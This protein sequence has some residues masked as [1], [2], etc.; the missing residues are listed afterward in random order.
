MA[1]AEKKARE[2]RLKKQ[3]ESLLERAEEHRIKAATEKGNKDTTHDYWLNEAERY[4]KQ[5]REREKILKKLKAKKKDR[6]N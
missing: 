5:A 1:K 4:E 2:K 3:E 6:K